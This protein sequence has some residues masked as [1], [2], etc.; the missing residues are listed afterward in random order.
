MAW[1]LRCFFLLVLAIISTGCIEPTE[2]EFQLGKPFYLVEGRIAAWA[3]GSQVTIRQSKFRDISLQ[4]EDVTEATVVA[5]AGAGTQVQWLPETGEAGSYRPPAEFAAATGQTWFLRISFPD[6]TVAESAPETVPPPP[7]L[8]GLAVAFA[9]EGRFDEGRNRFLPVFRILVDATDDGSRAD[10]YQWDF[11][12]WERSR[13]CKSCPFGVY[14]GGECIPAT[15]PD[16]D[17]YDYLCLD[18]DSCYQ[19]TPGGGLDYASDIG[20]SGG[21]IRGREIGDIEFIKY[22][23]LLVE[24]IQYGLTEEAYTYGKATADLVNGSGSL[25]P[26]IPAALTGNLRA[27]SGTE[28]DVLGF[29]AAVSVATQRR[30]TE[31]DPTT[32]QP[33]T[34][35]DRSD[36]LEPSVGFFVPPRAPCAGEGRSPIKPV[37]WP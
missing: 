15:I 26:T 32:G 3:G 22:G 19:V 12:Y 30:Y 2:P 31:R 7:Q 28:F 35:Y 23:G 4:F 1:L 25:N 16:G 20:F 21:S 13:I 11:R 24:A 10:F 33:S 36:R 9:Q 6:G 18:V 34:S 29:V 5:V 14:R 17:R 27:T 8:D 37:G